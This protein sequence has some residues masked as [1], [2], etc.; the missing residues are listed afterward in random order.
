MKAAVLALAAALLL[1]P[2]EGA[3]QQMREFSAARQRHGESRL[4]TRLDF[5][6]GSLRLAP[7]PVT[8]LYSLQLTYDVERFRPISRFDPVAGTV[9]LGLESTGRSGLRVSSREHLEQTAEV[10]LSPAVALDLDVALGAV[11]ANIE[12]GG[13]RL[14]SLRV[15]TGASRSAIRFST[16]NLA[17]CAVAV[18]EAGAAEVALTGLGNSRCDRITFSGGV[19]TALLDLSGVWTSDADLDVSMTMGEL[20]LRLP[21]NV[22]V[23]VEMAKFLSSFASAGWTREGNTYL[24]PGYATAER[25]VNISLSTTIGNVNVE[26][27]R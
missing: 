8:H 25:R 26:W 24:S 11:D 27:L 16:P 20:T 7:G 19:G 1:H 17:P 15:G 22:G 9:H 23:K 4:A 14:A 5:G 3:A 2:A 21:R 12:L 13:L 10:R 6:A 18:I